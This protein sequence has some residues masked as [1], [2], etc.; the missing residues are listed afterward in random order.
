MSSILGHNRVLRKLNVRGW[1]EKFCYQRR[2]ML[3]VRNLVCC[4]THREVVQTIF[5]DL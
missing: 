5:N 1:V 2:V 4:E 3:G